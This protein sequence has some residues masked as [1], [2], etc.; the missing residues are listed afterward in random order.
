MTKRKLRRRVTKTVVTTIDMNPNEMAAE[1]VRLRA[2]NKKLLVA[3][4]AARAVLRSVGNSKNST[5]NPH[6]TGTCSALIGAGCVCH[7]P[8]LQLA[9]VKAGVT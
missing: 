2:K 8:E 6:A 4:H 7:M 1:I 5:D 3:A 9:L